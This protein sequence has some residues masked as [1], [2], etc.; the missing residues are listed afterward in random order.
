MSRSIEQPPDLVIIGAGIAGLAVARSARRRGLRAARARPRPA[1]RCDDRG[2]RGHAGAGVRGGVR[3]AR[4][5]RAQSRRRRALA[6][7]GRGPGRRRD[8]CE[9]GTLLVARDRDQA[10]ALDR[11]L[12]FRHDCGLRAERLLPTAARR[13]EPALAPDRAPGAATC[14][15]TTSPTRQRSSRRSSTAIESGGGEIRTGVEVS[16]IEVGGDRVR[17]VRLAGG[18]RIPAPRVVV[19]AG[20][21]SGALS[22]IPESARVPVRPVKGQLLRLRDPAGPGL[23]ERVVRSEEMYLVP[24]GDGRYVL[25][26]TVE[27][28][29]F[30]T[31]ITAGALHD[32]LREAAEVVPGVLELEVTETA[33]RPAP[34]HARQR[35]GAGPRP[36]RRVCTGP[37]GTTATASCTPRSRARPSSPACSTS[38]CPR[39]RRRSPRALRVPRRAEVT[40]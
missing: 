34:R 31:A 4:P 23:V 3:G 32:L 27:E 5:A 25:G 38:R 7:V 14:P 1:G 24:R 11:E 8:G 36:R 19:A 10:E 21:W 30:D 20:P 22:G 37:P 29:G 9:C 39:R 13:L 12:A 16:E 2:R 26:A 15:T 40:A 18:E 35:A 6:R 33:G 28:R 17:G